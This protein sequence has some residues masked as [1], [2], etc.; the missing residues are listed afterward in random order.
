MLVF[1]YW[2]INLKSAHLFHF[3]SLFLAST[4][5]CSG[6]TI[7]DLFH[8]NLLAHFSLLVSLSSKKHTSNIFERQLI[9]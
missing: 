7:L 1:F 5:A 6:T 2:N 9:N 3:E 8:L 4:C